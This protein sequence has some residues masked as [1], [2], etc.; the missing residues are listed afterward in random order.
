M[1]WTRQSTNTSTFTTDGNTTTTSTP[2]FTLWTPGADSTEKVWEL[3]NSWTANAANDGSYLRFKYQDTSVF[4]LTPSGFASAK[5]R[6]I[7]LTALPDIDDASYSNGD[8]INYSG[9]LYVKGE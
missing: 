2:G 6:S 5:T 1:A 3:G 7:T 8:I 9:V 4:E